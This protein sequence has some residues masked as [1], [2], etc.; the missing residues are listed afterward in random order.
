MDVGDKA[1]I[2]F[3]ERLIFAIF[4]VILYMCQMNVKMEV[5]TIDTGK[6]RALAEMNQ[7]SQ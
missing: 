4:L 5:I 2:K 7:A 6:R 3:I 1:R